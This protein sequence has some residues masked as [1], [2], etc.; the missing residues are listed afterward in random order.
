MTPNALVTWRSAEAWWGEDE[1]EQ[2][3]CAEATVKEGE[4]LWGPI[5]EEELV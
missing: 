5:K 4:D 2:D 1:G 3:E